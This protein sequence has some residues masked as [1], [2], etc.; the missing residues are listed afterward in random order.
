VALGEAT[1]HIGEIS[2]DCAMFRICG[3]MSRH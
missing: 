1:I 2:I 3:D